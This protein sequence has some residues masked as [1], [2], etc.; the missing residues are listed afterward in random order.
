MAENIEKIGQAAH[1]TPISPNRIISG[2]KSRSLGGSK[3]WDDS[4]RN[5]RSSDKT[6]L[7]EGFN[8]VFVVDD[9]RTGPE[10]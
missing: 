8:E 7:F 10:F 5:V 9:S 4:C 1:R 6:S 3:T 2:R